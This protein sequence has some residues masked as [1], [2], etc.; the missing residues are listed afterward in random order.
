MAAMPADIWTCCS[1]GGENLAA[2]MDERCP[3]CG[4]EICSTCQPPGDSY[5]V[6][7]AV[8]LSTDSPPF[9]TSPFAGPS[10]RSSFG[11]LPACSSQEHDTNHTGGLNNA[12][13]ITDMEHDVWVCCQ[14]KS[15]NLAANSPERC[16]VC[17]HYQCSM[18]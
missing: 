12:G 14:C 15:A 4:H 10:A 11:R 18:C 13:V 5:N 8:G 1:C 2:L 3:I 16:P 6:T 9:A 17:S 7:L